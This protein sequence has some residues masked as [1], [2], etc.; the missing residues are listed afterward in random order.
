VY[1]S[2]Q[3]ENR[4]QEDA[5]PVGVSNQ[6]CIDQWLSHNN[7]IALK[8]S[9]LGLLVAKLSHANFKFSLGVL[10]TNFSAIFDKPT[11][12]GCIH[13][14][15]ILSFLFVFLIDRLEEFCL[16][17]ILIEKE[18]A[19]TSKTIDP[20][21]HIYRRLQIKT[22][23]NRAKKLN[24]PHATLLAPLCTELDLPPWSLSTTNVSVDDWWWMPNNHT[25]LSFRNSQQATSRSTVV[26]VGRWASHEPCRP[27]TCDAMH[28]KTDYISFIYTH[29]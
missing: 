25:S 19:N 10:L 14:H 6:L 26:A 24:K 7:Q 16:V 8:L 11:L 20:H 2:Q 27:I 1:Y 5:L 4:Q 28:Y 13:V 22:K 29:I 21:P 18:I 12:I 9:P 23:E 17:Y 3:G 15:C